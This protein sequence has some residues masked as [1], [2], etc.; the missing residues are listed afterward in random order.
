MGNESKSY[1]QQNRKNLLKF[2]QS[3][4]VEELMKQMVKKDKENL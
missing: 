3:N 4:N 1:F 2:K